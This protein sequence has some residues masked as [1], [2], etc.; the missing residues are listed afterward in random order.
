MS[1][2]TPNEALIASVIARSMKDPEFRQLLLQDADR[3]IEKVA[4]DNRPA[5]VRFKVVEEEADTIVLT[6][7]KAPRRPSALSDEQLHTVYGGMTGWTGQVICLCST[8]K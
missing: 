2:K 6:I 8:R 5:G 7:P 1:K 3:A 4:G